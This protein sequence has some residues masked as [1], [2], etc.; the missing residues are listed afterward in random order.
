MRTTSSCRQRSLLSNREA[1]PLRAVRDERVAAEVRGE[2]RLA[3]AP[4]RLVVE[5]GELASLPGLRIALDDEG[6][7]VG[8]VAV[9]MGDEGAVRV[10]AE[11]EGQ[12]VEHLPR[13]VPR[14][15]VAEDL[16]AGPELGFERGTDARVDPVRADHEVGARAKLRERLDGGLEAKRHAGFPAELMQG[17]EQIE[18]ADGREAIAVDRHR[19]VPMHDG[20]VRPPLH[21]RRDAVEGSGRR[22]P[23][24]LAPR[25]RQ[26]HPEA[27]GGGGGVLLVDADRPRGAAALE[28][29]CEPEAG[30]APRPPL[31][32]STG[33]SL[34]RTAPCG[35]RPPA[36]AARQAG[37][38]RPAPRRIS[39]CPIRFRIA[40]PWPIS[41]G[42]V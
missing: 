7:H 14:I 27:V 36:S 23:D 25:V 5:V 16:G 18:P 19:L 31:R 38:D 11:G 10:G 22:A 4:R 13:P 26:H 9:V 21:A 32:S 37:P 34:L 3:V 15:A 41:S 30:R 42:P 1:Q 24:P 12:G 6:A 17:P 2:D 40:Y 35:D 29:E 8:G 20:E 33:C 39:S 28:E